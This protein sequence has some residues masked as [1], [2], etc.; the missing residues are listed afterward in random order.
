MTELT[1]EMFLV[2]ET[3]PEQHEVQEVV[4][5]FGTKV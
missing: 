5:E 3:L 1:A 4:Q 2:Y